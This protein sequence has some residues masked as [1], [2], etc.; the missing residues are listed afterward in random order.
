MKQHSRSDRSPRR[1]PVPDVKEENERQ[2]DDHDDSGQQVELHSHQRPYTRRTGERR[3][4]L[5]VMHLG[6]GRLTVWAAATAGVLAYAWWA[7]GR[8][9][10]TTTATLTVVGAGLAAM[11]FGQ[12]GRRPND[13]RQALSGVVGWLVLLVALAGWQ[14]LAYV[15]EPRSEHPTL[16]SLTNTALDTRIG[17][18]LA[19]AA[20][21][22]AGSRLARR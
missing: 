15:Q 1:R 22:V 12:A 7:T 9:P 3:A 6:S 18:A 19:F 5:A 10:F 16:S 17:R 13:A 14:L 20:W 21:L 2:L 11:A 4:T 8:R